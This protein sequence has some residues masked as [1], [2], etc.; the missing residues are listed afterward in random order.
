MRGRLVDRARALLAPLLKLA[1]LTILARL[2]SVARIARIERSAIRPGHVGERAEQ[3]DK[4]GPDPERSQP[5]K[6]ENAEQISPGSLGR[7]RES[8]RRSGGV[9]H[10]RIRSGGSEHRIEHSKG[11]GT[12]PDPSR[13]TRSGRQS[14]NSVD[15]IV[16]A[17]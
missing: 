5:S 9:G 1:R 8:F 12:P 2:A 15:A 7:K 11:A 13:D 10:G 17:I 6:Q 16:T 3:Q 4:S 14:D